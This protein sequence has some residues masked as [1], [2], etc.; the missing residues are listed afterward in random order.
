MSLYQLH[1]IKA[2]ARW[3]RV[4]KGLAQ[5]ATKGVDPFWIFERAPALLSFETVKDA[6]SGLQ[7]PHRL[8]IGLVTVLRQLVGEFRFESQGIL[9][10]IV[11]ALEDK[12]VAHDGKTYTLLD[13]NAQ[14]RRTLAGRE[15]RGPRNTVGG[16]GIRL[17][18]EPDA[19]ERLGVGLLRREVERTGFW[20]DH[21]GGR[22]ESK[23]VLV[24]LPNERVPSSGQYQVCS[25]KGDGLGREASCAE[26]ETFPP[27]IEET[28]EYGWYAP[29]AV[30][31]GA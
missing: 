19:I 30:V 7:E 29:G 4:R 28:S 10:T 8:Q 20:T 27:T 18:H 5:I 12:Y 22:D 9:L 13:L 15:F 31:P 23:N 17:H 1:P 6:A 21:D 11:L 24:Y 25:A 16:Q 14:E 3:K 26:G 2:D